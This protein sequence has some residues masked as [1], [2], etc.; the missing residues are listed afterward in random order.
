MLSN[1][2]KSYFNFICFQGQDG[3]HHSVSRSIKGKSRKTTEERDY[4]EGRRKIDT[5][6]GTL[7]GWLDSGYVKPYWVI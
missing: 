6:K 2:F 5:R 7:V 3:T 4:R 1:I